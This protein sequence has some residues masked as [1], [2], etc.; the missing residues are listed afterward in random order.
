MGEYMKY[1]L[2]GTKCGKWNVLSYAG[3]KGRDSIYN[4]RCDC[5]LE[6]T[7]KGYYLKNGYS[8]QCVQCGHQNQII[9]GR[10][11]PNLFWRNIQYNAFKRNI[12]FDLTIDQIVDML[13]NQKHQ[14][15]IS[16]LPIEFAKSESQHLKGKT[17]VSID[18]INPNGCYETSNIQLVHKTIN[19]M[20]HILQNE[21]FVQ[22][23]EC[24]VNFQNQ[25][26]GK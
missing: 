15:A 10:K 11:L 9:K 19:Y 16:G 8:T 25:T 3:V 24:V 23:C 5:G 26:K 6:K 13:K 22:M 1:D 20:K 14:C 12:K 17:T 4:C 21:E 2:T 18:R 7:V